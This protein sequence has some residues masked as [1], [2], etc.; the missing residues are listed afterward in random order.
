MKPNQ[1]HTT[2]THRTLKGWGWGCQDCPATA[3]GYSDKK[4]A[5]RVAAIHEDPSRQGNQLVAATKNR[6]KP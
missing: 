2:V 5:A 4:Q 6:T 1:I 3:D